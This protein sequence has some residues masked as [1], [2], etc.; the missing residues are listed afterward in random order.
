MYHFINTFSIIVALTP[1]G[2][3]AIEKLR[4][5]SEGSDTYPTDINSSASTLPSPI[6]SRKSV[7]EVEEPRQIMRPSTTAIVQILEELPEDVAKHFAVSNI[8]NL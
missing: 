4:I 5:I 7:T 3:A 2:I 1:G 8:H 6:K